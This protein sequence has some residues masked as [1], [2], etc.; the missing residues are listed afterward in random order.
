MAD[1]AHIVQHAGADNSYSVGVALV[2]P[3]NPASGWESYTD[4][5][6]GCKR[7]CAR[8]PKK[9]VDACKALCE[10]LSDILGLP[11]T[12]PC[13]PDG[14]VLRGLLDASTAKSW[15]GFLGH[16]HVSATKW[17]PVPHIMQDISDAWRKEGK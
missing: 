2:N 10:A 14:T 4:V 3:G 8:S 16:I 6:H 9:Q 11:R 17:D 15:T 12:F 1:V 5:V 7:N 13:S